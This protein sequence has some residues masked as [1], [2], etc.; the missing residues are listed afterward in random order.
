MWPTEPMEAPFADIIGQEEP[1][2]RDAADTVRRPSLAKF[3]E[4]PQ[5]GTNRRCDD[6]YSGRTRAALRSRP[7]RPTRRRFSCAGSRS[8][9][10]VIRD[11]PKFSRFLLAGAVLA[12]AGPPDVRAQDDPTPVAPTDP[13]TLHDPL[14]LWELG[15]VAIGGY[16]P[17]YP[18]S[19]RNLA[20][21]QVL[22]YGIYRG[23][24]LRVDEGG[25]GVR[26]YRTPRFEWEASG[27][28]SFGSSADQVPARAG[29]PSI[30]KLVEFGP[31]LKINLGDLLD[32][33]REPRKTRLEIPVRAVFDVSDSFHHRGWTFEP[34]LTHV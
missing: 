23:S 31:A 25:V 11:F 1:A 27:S 8:A 20:A 24:V 18:G 21:G 5:A 30:G 19:D 9:R 15:L 34:R 12:F 29:M 33:R 4:R 16:Q 32:A 10:P 22:P 26:A 28:A 17:A 2:M 6:K 13:S 3:I 7:F 14:P